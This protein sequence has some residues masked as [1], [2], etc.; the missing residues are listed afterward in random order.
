MEEEKAF[1]T[2]LLPKNKIF[3]LLNVRPIMAS[4]DLLG[5]LQT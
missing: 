3:N 1:F 4:N 5:S 2:D